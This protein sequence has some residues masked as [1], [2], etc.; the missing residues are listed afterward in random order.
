MDLDYMKGLIKGKI[1]EM[2]FQEMFKQT[3]KF[4]IIPTGYEYN[5]PELAQYQNNLQNQNVISSIRTEPDFLLLTHGKNNERQAYF[6]EV[7][8]REEINP[9]DLIEISKK[10][11]EHWNPCWLFVASGDGFYFSPC[12]AVI[13]SQGK[14]EKLTE[15]WVK[16]EI[17]DKGLKVLQEYIKK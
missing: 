5:L 14:I 15:N 2:I 17:Q 3:G 11:L 10:L 16:K 9:I 7:K 8:Y 6:V 12:H 4:L 1:A 13:N